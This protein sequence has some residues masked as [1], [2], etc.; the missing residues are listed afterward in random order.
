MFIDVRE[1]ERGQREQH[2]YERETSIGCLPYA[3][4]LGI[5]PA[6]SVCALTRYQTCNLSVHRTMLRPA[7]PP[8]QG[9][10]FSIYAFLVLLQKNENS[11]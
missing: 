1:K 11:N 4:R 2:Q 5:D 6:T 3:P 9:V 10:T 7:A 8:G